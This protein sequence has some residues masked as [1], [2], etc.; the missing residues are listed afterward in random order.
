MVVRVVWTGGRRPAPGGTGRCARMGSAVRSDAHNDHSSS[1]RYADS[2][3][4][5]RYRDRSSCSHS[6]CWNLGR[7]QS[8]G[9]GYN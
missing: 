1:V 9:S 6:A 4:S 7:G 5:V 3:G 2:L 8:A